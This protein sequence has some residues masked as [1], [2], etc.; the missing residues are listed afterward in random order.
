MPQP[1]PAILIQESVHTTLST[2]HHTRKR[3]ST[4]PRTTHGPHF[5]NSIDSIGV[6]VSQHEGDSRKGH[7]WNGSM[8]EQWYWFVQ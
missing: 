2:T 6:L 5:V 7:H 4:D 3:P 1:A 8:F